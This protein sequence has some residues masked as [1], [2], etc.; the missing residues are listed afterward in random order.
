[1]PLDADFEER[2]NI[3]VQLGKESTAYFREME[4]TKDWLKPS[5]T[6]SVNVAHQH[7][8]TT[9]TSIKN[10]Q[11]LSHLKASILLLKYL[12]REHVNTNDAITTSMTDVE[13]KLSNH[14][15]SLMTAVLLVQHR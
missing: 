11:L 15:Q 13:T 10:P 6:P 7:L 8:K 4:W 14:K 1:M 3:I 9:A 5:C 12:Q 2:E